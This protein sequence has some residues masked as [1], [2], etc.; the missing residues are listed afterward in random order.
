MNGEVI[1]DYGKSKENFLME[2]TNS[3]SSSNHKASLTK[4]EQRED[5][6]KLY[7]WSIVLHTGRI[8]LNFITSVMGSYWRF[9]QESN[10]I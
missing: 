3:T 1:Q 9:K 5:R 8:N 4:A 7:L 2:G 6:A 10:G